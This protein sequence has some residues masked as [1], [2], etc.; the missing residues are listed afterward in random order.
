[1]NP[2]IYHKRAFNASSGGKFL[3]RGDVHQ[4]H[5]NSQVGYYRIR[6][7]F[8]KRNNR[9]MK[10]GRRSRFPGGRRIHGSG[11]RVLLRMCPVPVCKTPV[12][13]N[14]PSTKF[15][16]PARASVMRLVPAEASAGFSGMRAAMYRGHAGM[17]AKTPA[18]RRSR[19]VP[20]FG[21]C[22]ACC[23]AEVPRRFAFSDRSDRRGAS[24]RDG[25]GTS[26]PVC[27]QS[28]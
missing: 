23:F 14:S 24:S 13:R 28:C 15:S 26:V 10:P 19:P 22:A 20:Q 7:S 12:V 1:M 25:C 2:I 11:A 16:N 4:Q 9:S 27:R 3:E 17:H 8:S 5:Q 21:R 18:D 6:F